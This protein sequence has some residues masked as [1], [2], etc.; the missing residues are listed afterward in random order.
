MSRTVVTLCKGLQFGEAP[1]WHDG[2]LWFSDF[3]RRAVMSASE[4][5]DLR[6]EFEHDDQPS[7]LGWAPDGSLLF[8]SMIRR[9]VMRRFA[10]GLTVVHADLGH[11]ASFHCNDMVVDTSGTAYVGNFGFD[12]DAAIAQGG[13]AGVMGGHVKAKLARVTLDG[14]AETAADDLSFPNGCV[15]TPD[16]RQFIVAETFAAKLTAFD[17]DADGFLSG[18]RV[19]ADLGRRLPDGICLDADGAVWFANPTAPECV[20]VAEGGE[21]LEIVE[22]GDPCYACMLGGVDGRTLFLLTAGGSGAA[23]E[24]AQTG[25]LQSVRVDTPHAGLP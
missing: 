10:D 14:V 4:D 21:V 9:Q 3:F 17:I 11:I 23:A 12:L 24:S 8:V 6:V 7:G 1:R 22:T 15:I 19:W 5:G 13:L 18:R 25:R 20:R 16:G 2:R